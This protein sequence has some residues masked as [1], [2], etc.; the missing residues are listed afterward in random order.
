MIVSTMAKFDNK[1]PWPWPELPE[2]INQ[3]WKS[4]LLF[5]VHR[6][7]RKKSKNDTKQNIKQKVKTQFTQKQNN[8]TQS[9]IH[10]NYKHN[11]RV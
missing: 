11:A 5:Q 8:V 2:S 3:F 6:L 7:M 1:N 9:S 10:R 4:H